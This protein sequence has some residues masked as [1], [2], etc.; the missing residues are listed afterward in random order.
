MFNS[1]IAN[2]TDVAATFTGITQALRERAD[3][4]RAARF[5]V[6]VRRGGPNYK[7]GL[8]VMKKLGEELGIEMQVFGPEAS[9]TGICVMA[10]DWVRESGIAAPAG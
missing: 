4:L 2:F 6:F 1:G 5:R 8:A 10:A 7:S 3:A 9:M